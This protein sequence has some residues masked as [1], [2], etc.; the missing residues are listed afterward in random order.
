MDFTIPAFEQNGTLP[1]DLVEVT[2]AVHSEFLAGKPGYRMEPS[3]DG[4][5]AWVTE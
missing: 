4:K 2:E 5:P 3:A 1:D